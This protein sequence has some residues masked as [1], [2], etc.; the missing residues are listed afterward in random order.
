[1]KILFTICGRKGSKGLKNKNI[2]NFLGYPI[3]FYTLSAYQLFKNA[4]PEYDCELALNTDSNE[5]VEQIESFGETYT[6]IMRTDELAGDRVGKIDVIK[7]TYIKMGGDYDVVID[8]DLTSPIREVSD[9]EGVLNALLNNKD[10]DL[11]FSMTDSRRSPYFNQIREY[12]NGFYKPVNYT[13][14]VARQEVPA[15]FDMNAS[16]YA[17]KPDFLKKGIKL[18]DGKAAAYKMRDTAVLDIDN[19]EDKELMEILA[20]YF[21]RKFDKLNEVKKNIKKN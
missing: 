6:H 9:I 15:V 21:Y 5:L 13:G 19:P 18:F 20:E 10:A 7:D 14:A 1:M 11:S 8:L 17:Y 12:D 2:S 3:C 4:H 16:I